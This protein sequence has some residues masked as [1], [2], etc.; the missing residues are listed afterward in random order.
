MLRELFVQSFTLD[1]ISEKI[2]RAT[3]SEWAWALSSS[4]PYLHLDV[5]DSKEYVTGMHIW[6]FA[7]F[8]TTQ[9]IIRFGGMN[10][11]GVFTRDRKPKMAAHYLKERWTKEE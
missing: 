11:K 3:A 2:S 9:G 5:A 10:Y 8:K 6:A 7:D 1:A 4:Q